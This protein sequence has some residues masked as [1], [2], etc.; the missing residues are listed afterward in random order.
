MIPP[1]TPP[2]I[3][4]AT[5]IDSVSGVTGRFVARSTVG[6]VVDMS[7]GYAHESVFSSG[8]YYRVGED[9]WSPD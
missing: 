7:P 5:E 8:M 9:Y 1:I 2:V 4:P 6:V 3:V